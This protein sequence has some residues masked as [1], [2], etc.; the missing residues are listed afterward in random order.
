MKYNK[1][2]RLF[3]YNKKIE[4]KSNTLVQRAYRPKQTKS[5]AP[6]PSTINNIVSSF[7]KLALSTK[8]DV[9][10]K[11]NSKKREDATIPLKTLITENPTCSIRK[12]ASAVGI[13]PSLCR[14]ML[15]V[16]FKLTPYKRQYAQK[17]EIP[18]YEKRVNFA[19]WFL[20]R[21]Q[22]TIDYLV[23]SDEAYFYLTEKI[24]K[25]NDRVWL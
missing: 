8:C 14:S 24:N 15:T 17:L 20:E 4:L 6:D 2:E 11:I 9:S 19:K 5:K 12:A 1:E 25:Q 22:N 13:S 10:K 7:Q 18:D 16:D 23:C 21:P 3:L